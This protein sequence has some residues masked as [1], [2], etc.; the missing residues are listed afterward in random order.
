MT[1]SSVSLPAVVALLSLPALISC[2]VIA[3]EPAHVD[4]LLRVLPGAIEAAR[5]AA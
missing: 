2:T 4:E 1:R 3:H 5:L